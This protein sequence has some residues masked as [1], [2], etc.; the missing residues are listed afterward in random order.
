MINILEYATIEKL[1]L[2]SEEATQIEAYAGV[3]EESFRAFEK[4]SRISTEG[5]APLVT[6]LD[7]ENVLRDDI[8]YQMI[9]REDLLAN[10]PAQYEG[11]F[12]VPKALE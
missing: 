12:Q 3:L 9:S 11:Y 2:T 5:V 7:V 4:I 10:A 8:S 1:R 6:V